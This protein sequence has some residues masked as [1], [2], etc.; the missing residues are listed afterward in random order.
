[1]VHCVFKKKNENA[2][3]SGESP[4]V[5]ALL[6]IIKTPEGKPPEVETSAPLTSLQEKFIVTDTT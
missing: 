5:F 2:W 1:M 4:E 3:R 6:P